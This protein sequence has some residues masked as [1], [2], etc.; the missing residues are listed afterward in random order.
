MGFFLKKSGIINFEIYLSHE[1]YRLKYSTD[2]KINASNWNKETQRPKLQR[3]EQGKVN[4]K[5]THILNEYAQ[6]LDELKQ[7]HGKGLTKEIVKK[8]FNRHFK[9]IKEKQKEFYS[10]YFDEFIERKKENQTVKKVSIDRYIKVH[11]VIL[12]LQKK[13]K[14]KYKLD[15]FNNSFFSKLIGY[16]RTVKNISDNTLRRKIGFFKSFLNWCINNNYKVNM[17]YKTILIKGRETQHEHL[18]LEELDILE[19]LDLKEPKSYYRDIFL[20]GCY[21]GQ[22]YSDYSRFNRKY[23][24]NNIIKIRA[25]K[26]AQFSYIP[27]NKRLTRILDKY[28][29]I[30]P[31]ISAQKFNDHIHDICKIAGF[32][33]TVI[34]ERFYGNKKI[35]TEMPRYKLISSHTARR[36]FIT[37]S[38]LKNVPKQVVKQIT[39]IRDDRTLSN[40]QQYD[41]EQLNQTISDAWD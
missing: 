9:K 29:W 10:D 3:G 19:N 15:D 36:T 41:E 2:L 6:V 24:S 13:N 1:K 32:T 23:V 8:E 4:A 37:L 34:K 17:D 27:L 40:Y 30:L 39:G 35:V 11:E 18:T 12:E 31:R 25:K 20:I 16:L 5:I 22:R 28:D 38:G 21:S 14:T 7:Y 33:E 26:T